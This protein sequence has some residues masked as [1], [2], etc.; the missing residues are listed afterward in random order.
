MVLVHEK[1]LECYICGFVTGHDLIRYLPGTLIGYSTK[2]NIE[3]SHVFSV[4][5]VFDAA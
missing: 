5:V 1:L 4:T 2:D 3:S